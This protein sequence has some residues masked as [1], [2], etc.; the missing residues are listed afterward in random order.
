MAAPV[1]SADKDPRLFAATPY[2][3]KFFIE[4]RV[5]D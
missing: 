5:S 3:M 4:E 2:H 1:V